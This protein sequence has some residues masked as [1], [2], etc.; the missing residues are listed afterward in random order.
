MK[1]KLSPNSRGIIKTALGKYKRAVENSN[2][3]FFVNY[4]ESDENAQVMMFDRK[5]NL[6]SDNYFAFSEL[7]RVLEKS[8]YSWISKV[9]KE[10]WEENKEIW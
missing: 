5:R 4:E 2:H 1:V 9:L 7:T 8:E 10:L 3:I 6:I